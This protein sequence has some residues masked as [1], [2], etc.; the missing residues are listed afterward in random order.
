LQNNSI[1]NYNF[2]V[3][4]SRTSVSKF[5]VKAK[6]FPDTDNASKVIFVLHERSPTYSQF[7]LP[8]IPKLADNVLLIMEISLKNP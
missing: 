3:R 4:I 2:S 1:V 6:L 8:D 5:G 7:N